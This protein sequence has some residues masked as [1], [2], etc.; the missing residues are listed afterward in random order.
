[1]NIPF[2]LYRKKQKTANSSIQNL[3]G[4]VAEVYREF[5]E[6]TGYF[7]FIFIKLHLRGSPRI[8]LLSP[9]YLKIYNSL[10]G[11]FPGL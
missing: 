5:T 4:G 7:R 8:L 10:V 3:L 6:E 11:R 1:M 2:L 9:C